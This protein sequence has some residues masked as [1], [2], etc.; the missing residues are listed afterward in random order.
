VKV[1][2]PAARVGGSIRTI[3]EGGWVVETGPNTLQLEGEGDEA[4]LAAYGLRD[5]TQ[6][7]DMRSAKR[8]IYAHGKLHGFGGNPLALLLDQ[9]P[10]AQVVELGHRIGTTASTLAA[11]PFVRKPPQVVVTTGQ[12]ID[13]P[14]SISTGSC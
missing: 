9:Q 2:E 11:C 10:Q 12:T 4:L 3:R 6:T 1:I 13:R 5:A 14:L 7:A 8:Y